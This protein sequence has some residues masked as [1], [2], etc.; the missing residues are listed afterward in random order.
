MVR[1]SSMPTTILLV[2]SA[3]IAATIRIATD[4]AENRIEVMLDAPWLTGG[5][6][7]LDAMDSLSTSTIT[8][9]DCTESIAQRSVYRDQGDR[10]YGK[11]YRRHNR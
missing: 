10:Q 7:L 6:R 9:Y 5:S 11:K 3:E 4:T 8:E 2:E 1:G